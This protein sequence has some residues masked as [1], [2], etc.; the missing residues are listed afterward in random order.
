M[1]KRSRVEWRGYIPAMLTPFADDGA[2]DPIR[3][4]AHLEWLAAEGMH[5]LVI[6]G[7]TGEWTS[8]S[9]TERRDLFRL[10]GDQMK[11]RLP[12]IA[13]CTSYT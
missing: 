13:G 6:G 5:G 10:V 8:L 4:R 9:P 1:D 12:L 2:L 3:L 11:G 7:T